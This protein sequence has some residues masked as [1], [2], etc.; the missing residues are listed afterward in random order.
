MITVKKTNEL[1]P[2]ELITILKARVD[3]FVVEQNCPYQEVDDSD[4]DDLHV[5]L[6]ENNELKAYTR[7]IDKSDHITFGRVLVVEKYRK[8][9]LGKKIV[10]STINEI[11]QRFPDQPIQIQAQAYLQKFYASFGFKAISD[12]YLEDN[13]PHLDMLM[14]F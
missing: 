3:V 12:V 8:D 14:T 13:I 4:Y 1:S 11:K 5:C 2:K 7:I 10:A 6:I 9:G